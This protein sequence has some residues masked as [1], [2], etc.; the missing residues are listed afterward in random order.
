MSDFA[1][2]FL[3]LVRSSNDVSRACREAG[4][5]LAIRRARLPTEHAEQ[6]RRLV[7]IWIDPV[8]VDA[9]PEKICGPGLAFRACQFQIR[10][11]VGVSG[12][13]CLGW[14]DADHAR[15]SSDL[16]TTRETLVSAL[17]ADRPPHQQPRALQFI[18]VFDADDNCNFSL[19]QTERLQELFPGLIGQPMTWN[20]ATGA[21]AV[22]AD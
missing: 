6:G 10:E 11:S 2:C 13:W 12:I 8:M 7:G 3:L 21:W 18:P 15:K 9:P 22:L 17:I 4:E 19:L 1:N 20:T 16:G 5:F 14:V